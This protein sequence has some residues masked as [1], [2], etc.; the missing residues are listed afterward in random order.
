MR[1][2]IDKHRNKIKR[3]SKF[4]DQQLDT[5]YNNL[6]TRINFINEELI[7]P[8]QLAKIRGTRKKH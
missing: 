4:T 1:H 6:L 3:I 5:I 8:S 7:P 2:E